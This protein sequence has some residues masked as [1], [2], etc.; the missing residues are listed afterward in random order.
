MG[1]YSV[2]LYCI[3]FTFVVHLILFLQKLVLNLKLNLDQGVFIK[4]FKS[5]QP[6]ENQELQ[7]ID[8]VSF[9]SRF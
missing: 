7:L 8:Y 4:L 9:V 5:V 3:L 6:S 2:P 1:S